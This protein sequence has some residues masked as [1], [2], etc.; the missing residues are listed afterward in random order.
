MQDAANASAAQYLMNQLRPILE[1]QSKNII[2]ELKHA[3]RQG[4]LDEKTLVSRIAALVTIED[5]EL[6]IKAIINRG[7][8]P[9]KEIHDEYI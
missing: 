6:M 5:T 7:N 3:Y 1:I 4:N 8:K 2:N 9:L